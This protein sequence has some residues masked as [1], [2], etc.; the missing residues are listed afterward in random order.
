MPDRLKVGKNTI[1]THNAAPGGF[2]TGAYKQRVWPDTKRRDMVDSR[3][4][5]WRERE[6]RDADL[7]AVP[8]PEGCPRDSEDFPV[9]RGVPPRAGG[10]QNIG[11]KMVAPTET[12]LSVPLSGKVRVPG[13]PCRG[14]KLAQPPAG[15]NQP[16][17]IY[18]TEEFFANESPR[19]G[20]EKRSRKWTRNHIYREPYKIYG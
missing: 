1:L 12:N 19:R 15:A 20:L 4:A 7:R 11:M 16:W 10:N 18:P 13:R 3:G 17:R 8:H 9:W 2:S 6:C 5:L 14:L